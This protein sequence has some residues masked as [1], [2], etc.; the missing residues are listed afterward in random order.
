MRILY[1]TKGCT[2]TANPASSTP[3]A[4]TQLLT[5]YAISSS[6][7]H[8]DSF[9]NAAM[10]AARAVDHT[11]FDIIVVE[12][13][14]QIVKQFNGE[15]G[16]K[17]HGK[18]LWYSLLLHK[19]HSASP[20]SFMVVLT[21][22]QSATENASW[23]WDCFQTGIHQVTSI[24]TLHDLHTA[25]DRY[26]RVSQMKLSAK[27][28][29]GQEKVYQCPACEMAG[30]P[31]D[32]LHLHTPLYHANTLLQRAV[33]CPICLKTKHPYFV[34]LINSH[35]PPGRGEVPNENVPTNIVYPFALT[36][37]RRPSDN[38]FLMVQEYSNRSVPSGE[39]M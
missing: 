27:Q 37:V 35:G 23:R 13:T 38:K 11:P 9:S 32:A 30:L 20:L 34:H 17:M 31:E 8:Y 22:D 3:A 24:A 10:T 14:A 6:H 7:I 1:I 25:L 16:V 28:S 2:D 26:G 33:E 39:R 15:D 36:V 12:C 29:G 19:L 5:H 18:E 4:V 21:L